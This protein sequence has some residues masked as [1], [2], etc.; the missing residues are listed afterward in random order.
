ML[1]H[2]VSITEPCKRQVLNGENDTE[3]YEQFFL[4]RTCDVLHDG[5]QSLLTETS[6]LPSIFV[7]T[8]L[9]YPYRPPSREAGRGGG[10][11]LRYSKAVAVSDV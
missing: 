7:M 3:Q 9:V 10:V 5:S 6:S 11:D 2:S 1:L 8:S 4:S